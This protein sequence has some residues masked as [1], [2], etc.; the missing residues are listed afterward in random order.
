M[1]HY[2]YMGFVYFWIFILVIYFSVNGESIIIKLISHVHRLGIIHSFS[3]IVYYNILGIN[4]FS[5][6]EAPQVN[7]L[8]FI[9]INF[10]LVADL[11]VM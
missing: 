8:V 5:N 1:H 6:G 3:F 10:S 4:M 9:L 11:I 2:C 7:N